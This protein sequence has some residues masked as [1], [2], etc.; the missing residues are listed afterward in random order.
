MNRRK[1]KLEEL[2]R[3]DVEEFKRKKKFPVIVIADNI[4]SA[5]NV[6]SLFRTCDAFA[7]E[8][9]VLTGISARPPHKEITK[10][11]IGEWI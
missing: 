6:G 5:M 2:G 3:I 7:V 1:L 4:R 10:T 9:L 8:K 11:A